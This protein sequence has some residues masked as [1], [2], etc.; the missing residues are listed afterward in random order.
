M[1]RPAVRTNADVDF[2]IS[3]ADMETL[4]GMSVRDYGRSSRFPVFSG[5]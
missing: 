4:Q 5:K 3:D 2:V 1:G